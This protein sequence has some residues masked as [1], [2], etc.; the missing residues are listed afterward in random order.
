M[1]IALLSTYR[2]SGASHL[3]INPPFALQRRNCSS[4]ANKPDSE[5]LKHWPQVT[6]HQSQNLAY[7]YL[8]PRSY[9]GLHVDSTLRNQTFP[10]C[11]PSSLGT[12]S[13]HGAGQVSEAGPNSTEAPLSW[14][15][16]PALFRYVLYIGFFSGHVCFC[17][18]ERDQKAQSL[19]DASQ[20]DL[21]PLPC[22]DFPL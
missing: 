21:C 2:V 20:A 10:T 19:R 13:E 1:L 18:G 16:Q 17:F 15:E 22:Q 9:L 3:L 7:E 4:F 12:K 6:Q 8:A 14:W 11:S 5:R